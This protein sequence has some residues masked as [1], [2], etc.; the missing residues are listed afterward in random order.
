MAKHGQIGRPVRIASIGFPVGRSL[1]QV[2]AVVD[3]QGGQ[4]CDLVALPETRLGQENH[5][6]RPWRALPSRPCASW[7][8]ITRFTSSAPSIVWMASAD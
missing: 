6:P 8:I 3:T 1:D 7:R 4:G 5:G 2:C